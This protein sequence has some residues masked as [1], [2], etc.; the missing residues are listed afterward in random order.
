MKAQPG[1]LRLLCGGCGLSP[2]KVFPAP[3]KGL[4]RTLGDNP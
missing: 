2:S 1:A 3:V 4:L